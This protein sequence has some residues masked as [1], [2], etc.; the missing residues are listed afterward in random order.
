MS[1]LLL[2]LSC[3][4]FFA[5]LSLISSKDV[6]GVRSDSKIFCGLLSSSGLGLLRCGGGSGRPRK[7]EAAEPP[8]CFGCCLLDDKDKDDAEV[9]TAT[10]DF[11]K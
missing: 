10:G 3:S 9:D 7:T 11:G 5:D 8:R 2:L 1:T 6:V 4:L